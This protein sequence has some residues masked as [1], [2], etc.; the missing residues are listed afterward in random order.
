MNRLNYLYPNIFKKQ[1]YIVIKNYLNFLQKNIIKDYINKNPCLS[2]I[3]HK[4]NIDR[5]LTK[6]TIPQ[7]I[8]FIIN[9]PIHLFNYQIINKHYNINYCNSLNKNSNSDINC[10]INISD[11]DIT[12]SSIQ[13]SPYIYNDEH[14]KNGI[15][16]DSKIDELT[17]VNCPT[18]YGDIVLFNSSIPYRFSSNVNS[19]TIKA[20]NIKY[21]PAYI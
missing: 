13:F 12:S 19:S 6:G 16:D 5:I 3:Y 4:E 18:S 11:T 10:L 2:N 15:L 9:K 20:L 21:T 8:S 14:Y 1:S 7:Y 17:W